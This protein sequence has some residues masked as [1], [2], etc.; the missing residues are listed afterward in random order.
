[1]S[2][3]SSRVAGTTR[4]AIVDDDALLRDGLRRMIDTAEG[5][6]CRATFA[7]AEEALEGMPKGSCDVLLLDIG[8]AGLSGSEAV[9]LFRQADPGMVI[10]MLTV[11]SERSRVFAS[12]CNGASGYLLKSTPPSQLFDAI[13][14]ARA[15]GS[16]I[17]P[18]IASA[19]VKLFQNVG[20]VEP[21]TVPLTGQ[22]QLLLRAAVAGAQLSGGGA[23]DERQREHGPELRAQRLREAARSLQVRGRERGVAARTDRLAGRRAVERGHQRHLLLTVRAHAVEARDGGKHMRSLQG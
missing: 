6:S 7:S 23:A 22:E 5:F 13:S 11:F 3:E 20:P 2:H 10:L 1:M 8:L 9:P 15:G 19:I 14:A 21:P 12:I 17:S 4:V 18:E 16:P